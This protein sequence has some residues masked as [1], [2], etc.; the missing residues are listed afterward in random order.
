MFDIFYL[1][2]K[3]GL[4]VHERRA[5]SIRHAQTQSRTRYLW[6]VDGL[7]DYSSFDWLWEPPPGQQQQMHVWPS[8]HQDNGGTMLVP[9]IEFQDVNRDHD[10]VIRS[11]TVPRLH[12]HHGAQH[13]QQGDV[14]AR[15]ISDYLGTLKRLIAKIDAPFCWVTA[16]VCD[17][18]GF[19]WTWH[20]SEWQRDMLHVWPSNEQKFGDTFYV[21][22]SRFRQ[23]SQD[24]A[25]L[26]WYDTI[27]FVEDRS[28][29]R[30]PPTVIRHDQDTHVE[31]I[32]NCQCLDPVMV[33]TTR[34]IDTSLIPTVSLWREKT[35][36]VMPLDASGSTL[37]VPRTAVP[38]IKTQVYDYPWIDR[39]HR[40]H[41][42]CGTQDIVFISYDEP[43]AETN[44]QKLHERFPRAHRV[45]GVAGMENALVA[46]ARVS[47]TPWYFAVFAKTELADQFDFS[48]APD[49]LQQPK[50]Y[51]FDCQNTVNGLRYGHMGVVLYNVNYV[52]Q[53]QPYQD[54]DLDYTLSFPHE[55]VPELSCFGRFDSSA[56]HTWRTAFRE[57][58]KLA[59]YNH[60][61][62]SVETE[63]RLHTWC[64]QATGK[65]AEWCLHGAR[66]GVEFFKQCDGDLCALKHS[67]DWQWLHSRFTDRYG[68]ID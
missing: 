20:P 11:G 34:D 1:E 9:K 12:V 48:F 59:L 19:D 17:Y 29:P 27:H 10:T 42:A 14:D 43:Q 39:Q 44:W 36:T 16:D 52:L 5:D 15:Y 21:P 61:E 26:E 50:H 68:P 60:R 7:N 35:K 33:F 58:A 6:I 64:N 23:Q 30:R 40:Q 22:V 3:P 56:Y 66:D 28:V 2:K 13:D 62:P 18:T 41:L 67:F 63:Y 65:F 37:I 31:Q 53:E 47:S 54:L 24:I 46:A 55:V 4:F 38:Y 51:I 49:Y 57:C 32:K 8:Q 25:L 45:H